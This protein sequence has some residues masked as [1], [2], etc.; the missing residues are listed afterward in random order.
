M[1]AVHA[2]DHTTEGKDSGMYSFQ[3]GAAESDLRRR[4]SSAR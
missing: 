3:D 4:G 1:A 2:E